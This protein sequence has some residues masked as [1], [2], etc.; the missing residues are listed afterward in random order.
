MQRAVVG[1][2]KKPSL[3]WLDRVAL[4]LSAQRGSAP[5]G[6]SCLAAG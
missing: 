5:R 2:W 6:I 3:L 4:L 1:L